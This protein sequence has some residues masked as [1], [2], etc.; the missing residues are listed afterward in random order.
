MKPTTV[1]A[2]CLIL[3]ACGRATDASEAPRAAVPQAAAPPSG[4]A[5]E[6]APVGDGNPLNVPPAVYPAMP[7]RFTD[8]AALAPKGWRIEHRLSGDISADG[9]ADMVLVLKQN[10]PANVVRNEGFGP[11]A[12]D[13]NPRLLIVALGR[14]GG[15]DLVARNHTFIGRPLQPTLDDALESA[16][17]IQNGTLSIPLHFFTSAGGWTMFNSVSRFRWRDDALRLVGHDYS[18][19]ARNT[20]QT[21]DRS[22]NLLTGRV[23][24][25]RSTIDVDK[26][27]PAVWSTRPVGPLLTIDQLGDGLEYNP[28][29][30]DAD[31]EEPA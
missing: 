6:V 5:R 12:F 11:D 25:V 22:V 21:L 17:E 16:P 3:A 7:A 20:G 28:T 24:T 19:V 23:S 18:E 29:A 14:D 27:P 1:I 13:T 15:Y 10:D 26:D 9:V 30:D 31:V 8:P 4:W 2:A